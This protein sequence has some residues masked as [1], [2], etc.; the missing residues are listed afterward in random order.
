ME[1]EKLEKVLKA[2]NPLSCADVRKEFERLSHKSNSEP[3]T[4]ADEDLREHL[5]LCEECWLAFAERVAQKVESGEIP[6]AE[7]PKDLPVPPMDLFTVSAAAIEHPSL[8]I[9]WQKVW[10]SAQQG[11]K[12]AQEKVAQGR[13]WID[14]CTPLWSMKPAFEDGM[15]PSSV[16]TME[17][18]VL[19]AE[20]VDS[21]F[22]PKGG[23]V[24]LEIREGEG[25]RITADGRFTV[26]LH[27]SDRQWGAARA[28]CTLILADGQRVSFES[29]LQPAPAGQGCDV[30]FTAEGLPPG[31]ENVQVPLD[32][33]RLYILL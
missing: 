13:E 21:S 24:P 30:R 25:P 28:I 14:R 19:I 7:W 10:N 2:L 11:Q 15:G 33:L 5:L 4:E 18:Q 23:T 22:Q 26:T 32:F 31:V 9:M 3:S 17:A 6:L 27:T 8:G 29:I 20:V 12:W 16:S 1:N